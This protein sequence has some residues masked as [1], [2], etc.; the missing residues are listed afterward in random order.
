MNTGL[1]EY[2]DSMMLL[3]FVFI[4]LSVFLVAA[5]LSAMFF[6]AFSRQLCVRRLEY[7]RY[8]KEKGV[9]EGE[10]TELIEEFTNHSFLPMFVV[11]VETHVSSLIKM[12]GCQTDDGL[13]QCFISRFF[14]MPFT[15]IRRVHKAACLKRGYYRLESAK[16]T[17]AKVEVY[18]DS[19]AEIYIYPREL[20][21]EAEKIIN[22]YMQY[23]SVSKLPLIEDNFSFAGV[24]AYVHGDP[25]SA[26]N[27]KQT[28]RQRELMV[29]DREY[30]LGRKV[31]IYLNFQPNEKV[32]LSTAEF[33]ELLEKEL[34][35]ASFLLSEC[36]RN[37]Y[38]YSFCANSK[39]ANGER[40]VRT[41]FTVGEKNYE[42]ILCQMAQ[43]TDRYGISAAAMIDKDIME[44]LSGAEIF[45]FTAYIDEALELR[46]A[47]LEKS[48]N[49][50]TIINLIDDLS[51]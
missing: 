31:M 49:A 4:G 42:E 13:T 43:M 21:V 23:S 32:H 11:D 6:V 48:G 26:I 14:V 7:R 17:F 1:A 41:G 51:D 24:R 18:L 20:S 47:E 44:F 30:M 36:V 29:N 2:Q 46:T 16:I 33:A 12:K 34:S 3:A 28:A 25:L 37:G 39:M 38:A 22:G 27:Y 40:F 50:V 9:F 45:L 8:F 10:E 5:V 19:G 15:K 35:C